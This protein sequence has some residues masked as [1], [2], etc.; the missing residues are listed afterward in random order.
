LALAFGGIA[1]LSG[2]AALLFETLWF[3][4]AGLAFGNSVWASSIVLAGFMCGL[5]LGNLWAVRGGARIARPARAYALLEATVGVSGFA[6]VLALPA[7][8]FFVG[9][10]LGGAGALLLNPTRLA[11]AFALLVLPTSA[12]GAT[13]PLLVSSLARDGRTFGTTL[14]ALYGLNTLGGVAGALLGELVAIPRLGLRGTGLLA[15]GCDLAA[16]ALAVAVSTRV[17]RVEPA[18]EGGEESGALPIYLAA[19]A[20][21]AIVLGLEVVWFRF[22]VLFIEGFATSFAIMLAIVLLGVSLG[23]LLAGWLLKRRPGAAAL[24]SPFALAAGTATALA[25]SWFGEA[26]KIVGVSYTSDPRQMAVF[27]LW[28]MLPTAVFSGAL[29]TFLGALLRERLGSAARTTGAL[30][31]A[32]TIG[33]SLGSLFAGFVLLPGVGVEVSLA[34]LALLWILPAALVLR[35]L[36]E[37]Q[38]GVG[39]ALAAPTVAFCLALAL[40]PFGYL[41]NVVVPGIV[42]AYYGGRGRLV[43]V[44]TR[45]GLTETLIYIERVAFGEPNF[46][47]V[48]NGF[49]MSDTGFLARR[50]MQLF[51]YWPLALQGSPKSALVVS[52]GL[53]STANALTTIPSLRSI[54]VVDISKDVL[55][56]GHSFYPHPGT[57]PLDD[58]RVVPHVEDGRFFLL[59]TGKTFDI[60]TAEPPPLR[61]AGVVNLYTKEYFSLIRER[62]NPGG[63]V[64]YW[65]PIYQIAPRAARGLVRGFCDVFP[66]CTLWTG[67]RLEL[68]LVGSRGLPG[69][70]SLETF[71]RPWKDPSL[72]QALAWIGVDSPES[73][74]SLF[75]A[76][77][78]FLKAWVGDA[79]PLEDDRPGILTDYPFQGL[80]SDDP[81]YRALVDPRAAAERFRESAFI[82]AHWPKELVGATLPLFRDVA[83][84]DSLAR[85]G[86]QES[87]R[88]PLLYEI[89]RT[90][91]S[92]SLA[93]L[94][95]GGEP[96]EESEVEGAV[97]RGES[98]P[99]LDFWRGIGELS[100]RNYAEAASLF[101]STEAK[102]PKVSR[103]VEF[104]AL[105]LC[106]SGDRRG[107][108][109]E[110]RSH[111]R[112]IGGDPYW[113]RILSECR[114]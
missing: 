42:K 114:G 111:G 103:P 75:I 35:P 12:M 101:A 32:N 113:P 13:L 95:A 6:L 33:A 11:L 31:F 20:S 53:G 52:Y 86:Q 21:G 92:E 81:E 74:G 88:L 5:A 51:A 37:R 72:R 60:V 108:E 55:E 24:A 102:D 65:L 85:E 40:F 73:L 64:T 59:T 93:L 76:D 90:S 94:A 34:L 28:L 96:R 80:R 4:L 100:K 109:D 99:V 63:V 10:V 23:G 110:L 91:R 17:P 112:T 71:T 26:L 36:R 70:T 105:A 7:A 58:P 48:T 3:R 49:S 62:L 29:F 45:E 50:Y 18:P 69:P 57:S 79:L 8:T 43:A 27:S 83:L 15:A 19:G 84:F 14:G 106:L 30:T 2:T 87:F 56:L 61:H 38:G 68:M 77:A 16:A 39:V 82:A 107:A 98:S 46:Q 1:L 41:R 44:T 89:L 66:D 25:Y 78:P 54:D 104:R 67:Q 47:L 97:A 9:R 22:L